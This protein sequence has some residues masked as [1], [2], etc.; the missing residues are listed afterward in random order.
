MRHAKANGEEERPFFALDPVV[1]L[2]EVSVCEER[3][4][5]EEREGVEMHPR[6]T[7]D[8]E[9]GL[10]DVGG[11]HLHFNPGIMRTSETFQ[12]SCIVNVHVESV[13]RGQGTGGLV[14]TKVAVSS[15]QNILQRRVF[16]RATLSWL[17][18]RI[19][20]TPMWLSFHEHI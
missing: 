5:R 18:H 6:W 3:V 9:A 14:N 11:R 17:R 16:S 20:T 4:K 1:V 10:S 2:D 12:F 13:D 7:A 19:A 15:L 8:M